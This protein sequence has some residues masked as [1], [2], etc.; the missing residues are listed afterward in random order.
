MC[1]R[2][3]WLFL[4]LSTLIVASDTH[5]L[6]ASRENEFTLLR[7]LELKLAPARIEQMRLV[8]RDGAKRFIVQRPRSWS[9]IDG[10]K[11]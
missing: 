10:N 8:P 1:S 9:R 5:Q 3:H 7:A 2:S 11:F 6:M 4:A